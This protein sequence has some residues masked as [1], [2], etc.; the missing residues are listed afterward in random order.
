MATP[1]IIGLSVATAALVA[2]S[3]IIGFTNFMSRPRVRNFYKGGF[4]PEMSRREAGLI[5]GLRESAPAEKIKEA[6]RKLMIANHPDSGGSSYL[7]TKI[8][9]AKDLLLGKKTSGSAF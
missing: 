9:E 3:S 6:H 7:A 5:L 8:N 4:L 1:M 2:R